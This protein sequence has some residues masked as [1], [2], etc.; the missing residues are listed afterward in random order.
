MTAEDRIAAVLDEMIQRGEGYLNVPP[1]DGRMLR[2][3]TAASGAKNVVEIG[4]S[5]GYSGLW[6]SLALQATGGRLTTFEMDRG[7]I[8]A[9]QEHFRKAGVDGLITI[10][11]GDAHANVK[12]LKGPI[13]L[14]FIDADKEG[15]ID[16]VNKLLPL[17]RPSGLI[18][19]HN[20]D[21]VPD[22][23]KLVTANRDLE[24]VMYM[25]GNGLAITLKKR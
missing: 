22:Y 19:A 1:K 15:Y 14:L 17:V 9:A 11:E 24:T 23:V 3:L 25:E 13:D 2:V 12:R 8:A 16:Y 7:R 18:L 4:T 10:V 6:F 20:V 5:T 21:M